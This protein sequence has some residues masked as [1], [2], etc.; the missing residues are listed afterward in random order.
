M[1]VTHTLLALYLLLLVS[2]THSIAWPYGSHMLPRV[3]ITYVWLTV[4][5]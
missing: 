4:I 2:H 5:W 3:T 1:A